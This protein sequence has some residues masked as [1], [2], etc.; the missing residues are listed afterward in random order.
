MNKP[1]IIS[2]TAFWND[3]KEVIVR[4]CQVGLYPGDEPPKDDDD[5]FYYFSET[6]TIIGNQGEFT[7]TAFEYEA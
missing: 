2:I 6:E 7:V 4:T 1:G 3:T 5:I